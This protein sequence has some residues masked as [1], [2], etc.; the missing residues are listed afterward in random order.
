MGEAVTVKILF[1]GK[2]RELV[3]LSS[4]EVVLQSTFSKDQIVSCLES[5]FEGLIQLRG[6]YVLAVNEEYL[7]AS[8]SLQLSSGSVLNLIHLEK[9]L[10]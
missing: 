1:F 2:A 7:T 8:E 4:S 3:K 5:K 9:I 6:C 10:L